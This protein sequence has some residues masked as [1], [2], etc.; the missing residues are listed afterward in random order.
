MKMNYTCQVIICCHATKIV[1][2]VSRVIAWYNTSHILKFTYPKSYIKDL[3]HFL[4]ISFLLESNNKSLNCSNLDFPSLDCKYECTKGFID[5]KYHNIHSSYALNQFDKI[6]KYFLF[7]RLIIFCKPK[8]NNLF[9]PIN[10]VMPQMIHG[11]VHL[12]SNGKDMIND[13]P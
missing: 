8:E 7:Y 10:P 6:S 3:G 11:G 9:K 12:A 4:T 13:E 5:M 1:P 2:N